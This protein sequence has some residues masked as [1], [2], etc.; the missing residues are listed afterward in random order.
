MKPAFD[1]SGTITSANASKINDGA[2]C[3]ILMSSKK[4]IEKNIKPLARILAYADA[5]IES[6]DFCRSPYYATMKALKKAGLKV[7]DIDF[8]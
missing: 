5:E 4:M 7:E 6:T 8:F 3:M 1:K 2:C